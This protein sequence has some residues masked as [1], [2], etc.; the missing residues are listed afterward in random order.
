MCEF[1]DPGVRRGCREPVADDVSD[2]ERANFCGYFTPLAGAGPGVEDGTARAARAE[3][4]AL[5]GGPSSSPASP[6]D[7]DEARRR[8]EA[9]FGSD[10][11]P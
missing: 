9:L 5:F 4:D 2:R 11:K 1:F 10:S 7:A 3:L 8:L 6:D